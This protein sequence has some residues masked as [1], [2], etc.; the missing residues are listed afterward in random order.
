[1]NFEHGFP[2]ASRGKPCTAVHHLIS[3]FHCSRKWSHHN[4]TMEAGHRMELVEAIRKAKEKVGLSP[5]V[6]GVS[7]YE[8]G[9][10][11][12]WLHR[13]LEALTKPSARDLDI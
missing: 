6:R 2:T 7:C 10:D 12:F 11:G 9:R 3:S 8:A 4:E 13:Y 5:E 1:M